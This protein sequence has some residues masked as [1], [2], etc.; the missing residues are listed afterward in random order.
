M[1]KTQ[2]QMPYQI[3]ANTLDKSCQLALDLIDL[4][5]VI[6]GNKPEQSRR[7]TS[8][9]DKA[10][11]ATASVKSLML[12]IKKEKQEMNSARIGQIKKLQ[13]KYR[14]KST[15]LKFSKGTLLTKGNDAN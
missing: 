1:S 13:K 14:I 8:C 6:Y 15:N 4:L 11:Y 2:K 7:L 9:F 10:I 5:A 3:S 12:A